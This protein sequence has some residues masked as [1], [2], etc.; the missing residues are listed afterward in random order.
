MPYRRTESVMRR[1]ADREQTIVEAARSAARAG[2]MQAVQIAA[3]AE[4][5]GIASGT[6]YR[7][8]QSKSDLISELIGTDRQRS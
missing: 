2:G 6:V 8:F 3:V 1:L 4:R 5:A 7:Y